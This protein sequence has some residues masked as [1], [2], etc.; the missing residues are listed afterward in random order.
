MS[1]TG[2]RT[3]RHHVQLNHQAEF[4]KVEGWLGRTMDNYL[5]RLEQTAK[6]GMVGLKDPT[7][8]ALKKPY[9]SQDV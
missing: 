1:V 8:G 4:A 2:Y 7:V 6:E 5:W 3:L 9:R